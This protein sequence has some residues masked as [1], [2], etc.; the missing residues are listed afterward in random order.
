MIPAAPEAGMVV[1][2]SFLWSHEAAR[3]GSEGAKDRPVVVLVL[4]A[5]GE[6]AVVAPVTTRAP[7][8]DEPAVEIPRA[9]RRHLGLDAD[10]CWI[11]LATL[12]RFVWPGPDLRP[13]PKRR[14]AT[15]LYG[16]VP[17]ELLDAARARAMAALARRAPGLVVVRGE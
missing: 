16:Y 17:Q 2:Y 10:R 3:G 9:V 15:T 1:R 5:D 13:I 11:S 12:N 7:H 4:M 14:P 8:G 6:E